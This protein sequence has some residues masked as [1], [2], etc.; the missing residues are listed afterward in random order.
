MTEHYLLDLT[1]A[2]IGGII[3]GSAGIVVAWYTLKRRA[4]DEVKESIYI[5]LYNAIMN[6]K[7]E[8]FFDGYVEDTWNKLSNHLKLKVDDKV[9][10]L[11]EKYTSIGKKYHDVLIEWEN[12]YNEKRPDFLL[13]IEKVFHAFDLYKDGRFTI[14]ASYDV[15]IDSFVN[16]FHKILFD[17]NINNAED[18]YKNLLEYSKIRNPDFNDWFKKMH[19]EKPRWFDE[20]FT[21]LQEIKKTFPENIDYSEL[22]EKRNILKDLIIEIREELKKRI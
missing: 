20:L 21:T 1:G 8:P 14:R 5:P 10:E 9:K 3:S 6:H 19:D 2:I 12:E 7:L 22:V 15:G 11:Y 18:L 16:W 4:K 17:H 13:K